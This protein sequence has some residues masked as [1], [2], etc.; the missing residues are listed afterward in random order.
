LDAR[1]TNLFDNGHLPYS[2][3]AWPQMLCVDADGSVSDSPL[4]VTIRLGG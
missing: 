4:F 1:V 2:S 3:F